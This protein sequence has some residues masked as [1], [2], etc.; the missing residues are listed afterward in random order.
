MNSAVIISL[1]TMTVRMTVPYLY[2][3]L[4]DVFTEIGRTES[5]A[6]RSHDCGCFYGIHGNL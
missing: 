4:G 3:S 6:G 5:W 2:A 1:L